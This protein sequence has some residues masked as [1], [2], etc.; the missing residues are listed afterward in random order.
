MLHVLHDLRY[1]AAGTTSAKQQKGLITEWQDQ[2]F[3]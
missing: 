2:V 1:M 3:R